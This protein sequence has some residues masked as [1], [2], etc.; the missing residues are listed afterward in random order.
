MVQNGRKWPVHIVRTKYKSWRNE[1]V[2]FRLFF[3]LIHV[4]GVSAGNKKVPKGSYI[5]IYTGELLMEW[6][7]KPVAG[8]CVIL[9]DGPAYVLTVAAGCMICMVGRICFRLT[10]TT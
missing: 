5:G 9:S 7:A 3:L 2:P 10:F 6:Q 4:T 1:L 8:A